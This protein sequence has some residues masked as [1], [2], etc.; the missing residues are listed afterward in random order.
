VV[1]RL[2]RS[3]LESAARFASAAADAALH[4][5]RADQWLV[6]TLARL[7]PSERIV[8]SQ[9]DAQETSWIGAAW[10][11]PAW[12]PSEGEWRVSMGAENP[13]CLYAE[14]SG[15]QF[16]SARRLNEVADV[17]RLRRTEYGEVFGELHE[18]QTRLP[19]GETL[20]TLSFERSGRNYTRRDTTLLDFLR[21]ALM[22]FESSRSIVARLAAVEAAPAVHDEDLTARESEILNLVA[23]GASNTDIAHRLSISVGTV[24]KHLEH[25]YEKLGAASRTE[26]L[27]RTGRTVSALGS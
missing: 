6:E 11:E 22:A 16:F 7:I 18:M 17:A 10:P 21:P 14:H 27:A 13:W 9:V 3:D 15:D 23:G 24:R 1:T 5:E 19:G 8:Y 20:W 2:T 25:V 12:Q 26:A 4:G